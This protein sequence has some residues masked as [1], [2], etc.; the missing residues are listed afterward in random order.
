M[1]SKPKAELRI[2]TNLADARAWCDELRE[3]RLNPEGVAAVDAME[4]ALLAMLDAAEASRG[5]GG[6]LAIVLKSM[7]AIE[8]QFRVAF[9]ADRLALDRELEDLRARLDAKDAAE[10]ALGAMH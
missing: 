2:P 3:R 4:L 5:P 9:A 8:K 7:P 6:R 10:D 1:A